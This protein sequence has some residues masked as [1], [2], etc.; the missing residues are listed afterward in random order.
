MVGRHDGVSI[1]STGSEAGPPPA[2]RPQQGRGVPHFLT[3]QDMSAQFA[4]TGALSRFDVAG[5]SLLQHPASELEAGLGNLWLRRDDLVVPLLGSGTGARVQGEPPVVTGTAL[6]VRYRVSLHFSPDVLA[7]VWRVG[8]AVE[9]VE[10]V[11]VSLLHTQDV[12]LAPYEVLR[13]NEFYVSQYLDLTPVELPDH[14]TAVAVRQNMPGKQVP[15]ALI[16][17]LGV[18]EQWATDGR[19]LTSTASGRA[20]LDLSGGLPSRRLQG[21]HTLV[22]LGAAPLTLVP[23]RQTTSGFFGVLVPDHPAATSSADRSL[24]EA[25]FVFAE[26]LAQ[27]A[28][29]DLVGDGR[30][31]RDPDTGEPEAPATSLFDHPPLVCDDLDEPEVHRLFG[32]DRA[33]VESDPKGGLWSFQIGEGAEAEVVTLAAKERAVLRPHGHMLRTGSALAPDT[34]LLTSTVWMAG[35]FASQ[36]SQGHVNQGVAISARRTYLGLMQAHGLRIFIDR[37]EG[38]RLLVEP[39]AWALRPDRARWLYRADDLLLEVIAEAPTDRHHLPLTLRVIEGSPS[40][41]LVAC[42]VALGDDLGQVPA[43]LEVDVTESPDGTGVTVALGDRSFTSHWRSDGAAAFGGDELLFDDGVSRRQPWLVAEFGAVTEIDLSLTLD[44]VATELARAAADHL[45]D[46]WRTVTTRLGV[47]PPALGPDAIAG[48]EVGVLDSTLRWFAHNALIHHLSPRG[49]EQ[50]SGGGW[51]TR[52]VSQGPVGLL[53]ALAADEAQRTTLL[54][55]LAAQNERGDWP[56]AFDFLPPGGRWAQFESHGDVVLW[57]VLAVGDYLRLTG[58]RDFLDVLVPFSGEAGPTGPRPVAE[59]LSRALDH[60]GEHLVP[61]SS[62]PAYG[63]GDWNDSLQ[64]ADPAL[65]HQMVSTWTSVLQTEALRHLAEGVRGVAGDDRALLGLAERSA[66]LAG[67]TLHDLR[68]LLLV[69]GELAGYGVFPEPGHTPGGPVE[70]L[71]HPRDSRTGLTH[72]VLPWIHAISGQQL[73]PDEADHHLQL[74]ADHLLGPDGARLFD[75]PAQYRGGPMEIFQ[76][77]EGATFWGREI[78]LMYTHAHLRYAE[79]LATMG[80][81][82]E[83][84]RA[85]LL[86]CPAALTDRLPQARPRQTTCYYSSS[87]ADFA[88]RWEAE[89]RYPDL[90]AGEVPLEGGWRIYS[91]GPGLFLRL[92]TENLFGVRRRGDRVELD[93]VLPAALDGL[94]ARVPVTDGHLTVTYR[95]RGTGAGVRAVTVD[96][97]P[98]VGQPLDN[99]YRTPGWSVEAAPFRAGAA[100]VVEVG[101]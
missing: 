33:L 86:V 23:G 91:S 35:V 53:T 72:G 80:R 71:V 37:G 40:R 2:V 74:I 52:D 51:G 81:A 9:G 17:A 66:S 63:H 58:D 78:G 96:G 41:V 101:A 30:H 20:R 82:E 87:D 90:M 49:L 46:P 18:G 25:A 68:E 21:E 83:F 98:M 55:L 69:D 39:S 27:G 12:A 43:P 5:L 88:D 8:L 60:I 85:L 15:W 3:C 77:A 59:H 95:V 100:V 34:D 75:R 29:D 61:G 7:W 62:L 94:V 93:P 50:F 24:A 54:D 57:P 42:H 13:L 19:Q 31:R 14:G 26:G 73:T 1:D 4:S 64:P 32:A 84:W 48:R 47:T 89:R 67:A 56:Q 65:A 99:H 16:G 44:V 28:T 45:P 97:Q 10:N 92:V 70:L 36:V 79:A 76:R 38:A 6:G 22:A 11:E